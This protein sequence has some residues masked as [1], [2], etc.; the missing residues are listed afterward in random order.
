MLRARVNVA[1]SLVLA[2]GC[3]GGSGGPGGNG[4]GS[5]G[6]GGTE[7]TGGATGLGGNGPIFTGGDGNIGLGGSANE[8]HNIVSLRIEPADAVLDVGVG[9]SLQQAF[10]AHAVFADA[11][12]QEV[13]ITSQAV[14]YVPD[15]YLVA[16]FPADGSSTLTTRVPAPDTDEPAQ[17]GGSLTVQA[18]AASEDGTIATA[19]TSLTVRLAGA[20]EP[21]DPYGPYATPA[22]PDNPASAFTGEPVVARAPVLVY[23]NDGTL[24]PPNLGRLEV[25]FQP[26]AAENTLFEVRFQSE[27]S[28]L[29]YFTRCYAPGQGESNPANQLFEPGSC[30]FFLEDDELELL[31]SSNQGR[32][33]V[34]LSVRGSDGSGVFGQSA[35]FDIEFA[36]K[37]IDGAVYYWTASAPP[38]IMRFDFGSAASL[39][40]VFV[41]AADIPADQRA[42]STCVGCHSLSRQGDKVIFGLGSAPTARLVYVDDMSRA[43][44]DTDFFTYTGPTS[45]PNAVANGSFNP[46]GTQFVAVTP[47]A[48][49]VDAE[50]ILRFHDGVSGAR[51]SQLA[52]PVLPNNPDWSPKGDKIAFSAIGGAEKNRI[53]FLG[54]GISYVQRQDDVWDAN[55]VVLVP[56]V[57]G[58]NR[59]NPTFFPDGDLLLFSE[60][61]QATYTDGDANACNASTAD[62]DGRFCNGYSDPGAKTWAVAPQQGATP[63][64]LARAAAPGVA[65]ELATSAPQ[66]TVAKTDLMD[67]FP[68]PSPFEITHRGTTVGWFTV[69]SQRRAGL[70]KKFLN[71]SIV[72][73]PDSQAL[74]WMFAVDTGRIKAGEDGSYPGF[75][76]PFQDLKTSNHMAQWTERIVSDAPPPPAPTPPP[77]AP[78]PIPILR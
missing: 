62:G 35:S 1:L 56:A 36:E 18:Q 65:D 26:G 72:G 30:T 64:L 6:L 25:H 20:S 71:G 40:E 77:P 23:P 12:D 59:F 45:D 52:L 39:P 22:L 68:K 27:V 24:L 37:R 5:D 33:P 34:T 43:I 38:S 16:S 47:A 67:T 29:V 50:A 19:T 17:R 73:E 55:P 69:G 46:D 3:G 49:G 15:N 41:R 9:S 58:K 61:E 10:T 28:D 75:F 2:A 11:P 14:F 53:Q 63:V 7:N 21:D 57:A 74:L 8:P 42:G 32:G 66:P 76:L 60:V 51:V 48:T 78:P 54:S 4:A 13:D 70:R 44:D 31:A